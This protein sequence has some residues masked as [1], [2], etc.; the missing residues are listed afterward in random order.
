MAL[1]PRYPWKESRRDFVLKPPEQ[2]G[3]R[4]GRHR[5]RLPRCP[6]GGRGAAHRAPALP[7]EPRQLGPRDTTGAVRQ[8]QYDAV[9]TGSRPTCSFN[10]SMT[11]RS[12][13]RSPRP[14]GSST[15][16][17]AVCSPSFSGHPP[18]GRR[19]NSR[20]SAGTHS[21]PGSYHPKSFCVPVLS[22]RLR[23]LPN[24]AENHRNPMKTFH[25]RGGNPGCDGGPDHSLPPAAEESNLG[26]RP[27]C[28][29]RRPL[30]WLAGWQ[31]KPASSRAQAGACDAPL[32]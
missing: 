28:L 19:Y 7:R 20:R 4:G 22:R 10:S 13:I 24:A 2:A 1:D 21:D 3:Q 27:E 23:A 8:A 14:I 25:L 16:T 9:C 15:E 6:P 30:I 26:E 11:Q 5:L 18:P 32:S 17:R 29:D 31:G 12:S